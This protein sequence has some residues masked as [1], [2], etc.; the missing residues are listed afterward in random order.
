MNFQAVAEQNTTTSNSAQIKNI[1]VL[2]Q[3]IELDA[4]DKQQLTDILL[5]YETPSLP[6]DVINLK[7]VINGSVYLL[8]ARKQDYYGIQIVLSKEKGKWLVLKKVDFIY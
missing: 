1:V 3:A 6:F 5:N 7:S 8:S 4:N 2:N